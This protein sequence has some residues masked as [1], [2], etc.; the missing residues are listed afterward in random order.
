MLDWRPVRETGDTHNAANANDA[1]RHDRASKQEVLDALRRT[2]RRSAGFLR[3]LTDSELERGSMHGLAGREM[4]VAQFAPNFARHI[5]G[6][7]E[8]LRATR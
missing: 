7:L 1:R 5:R 2:T 4:T 8:S 6:H 3:S